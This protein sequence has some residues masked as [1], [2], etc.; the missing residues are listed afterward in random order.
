MDRWHFTVTIEPV[1]DEDELFE[2]GCG[3]ATLTVLD[4]KMVAD[5]TRLGGSMGEAVQSAC[6]DIERAGGRVVLITK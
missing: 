3:D 6:R 4:G 5:F 2:A 1:V